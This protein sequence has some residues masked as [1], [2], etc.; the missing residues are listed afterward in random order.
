[1]LY[2]SRRRG[3]G[4]SGAGRREEARGVLG[5]TRDLIGAMLAVAR[6]ASA[7]VIGGKRGEG[8]R[9]KVA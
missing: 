1:M 4:M 5:V 9:G 3:D 8:R 7:L 6:V 2:A